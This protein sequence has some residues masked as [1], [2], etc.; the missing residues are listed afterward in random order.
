[1]RL[2]LL[3]VVVVGVGIPGGEGLLVVSPAVQHVEGVVGVVPGVAVGPSDPES[4][5]KVF[6]LTVIL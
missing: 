1:M 4:W 6:P 2:Q 5:L 3:L